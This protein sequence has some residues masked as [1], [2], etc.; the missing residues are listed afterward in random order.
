MKKGDDVIGLIGDQT[1]FVVPTDEHMGSDSSES[2][3]QMI[4]N[5]KDTLLAGE[6]RKRLKFADIE[7]LEAH[8][9]LQ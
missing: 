8:L 5:R 6:D 9:E 1:A 7:K 3:L 2:R 4:P